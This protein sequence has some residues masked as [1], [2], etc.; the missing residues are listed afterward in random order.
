MRETTH[1][2]FQ[3]WK[4]LLLIGGADLR[5]G[6]DKHLYVLFWYPYLDFG[7]M[8]ENIVDH[9]DEQMNTDFLELEKARGEMVFWV[10]NCDHLPSEVKGISKERFRSVKSD[11]VADLR[12]CLALS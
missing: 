9:L 3:E 12:I 6:K 10:Q 2:K 7:D 8:Q 4:I 1:L 11:L 5:R